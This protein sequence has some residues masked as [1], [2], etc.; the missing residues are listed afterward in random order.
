MPHDTLAQY[1]RS[2]SVNWCLVESYRN[3]EQST[4]W[5]HVS[6]EERLYFFTFR[7]IDNENKVDKKYKKSI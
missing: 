5:A 2:Y 4:L 7:D 6:L 1:P 3:G